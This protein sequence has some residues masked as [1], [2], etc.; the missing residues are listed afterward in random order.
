MMPRAVDSRL[1]RLALIGES[2]HPL[3]PQ[4]LKSKIRV[5]VDRVGRLPLLT[6]SRMHIASKE[7][8]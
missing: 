2:D 4:L 3:V 8:W 6:L 7:G 1:C 5:V